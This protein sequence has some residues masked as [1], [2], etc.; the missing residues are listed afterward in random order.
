[1][2]IRSLSTENGR[3]LIWN[4]S[5]YGDL[6]IVIAGGGMYYNHPIVVYSS[7]ALCQ[8]AHLTGLVTIIKLFFT[9]HKRVR[10]KAFWFV[11]KPPVRHV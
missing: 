7:W 2:R 4:A 11:S 10:K 1:M 3:V 6:P 9:T 5:P 8:T